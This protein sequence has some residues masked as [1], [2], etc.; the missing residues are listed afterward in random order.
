M[1]RGAEGSEVEGSWAAGGCY[2]AEVVVVVSSTLISISL[3]IMKL[4]MK[5]HAEEMEADWQ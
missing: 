2:R 3:F 1:A 4:Y 5:G